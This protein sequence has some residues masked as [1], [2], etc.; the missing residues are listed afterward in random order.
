MP[1]LPY[2]ETLPEVARDVSLDDEAYVIGK[3]RIGPGA[4]IGP[5]S[6]IRG[7]QC[8]I[9][10]GRRF[11]MGASA[12]VHVDPERPTTIGEDVLVEDAAVVHGCTVGNG[13][14]IEREATVLTGSVVGEGS[15]VQADALVAEGKEIPPR[16][17]VAG[18]PGRVVR[19]TTD[20]EVAEIRR[21]AG[22][23]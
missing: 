22:G 11:R 7:D 21:R 5:R 1:I 13:V 17:V 2:L 8:H 20:D 14:L 23:A 16:S 12:T 4:R 10:I 6:V 15:I 19:Q 9:T 3:V 18:T